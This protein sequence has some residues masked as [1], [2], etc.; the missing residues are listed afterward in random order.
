MNENRNKISS[1]KKITVVYLKVKMK[2]IPKRETDPDPRKKV[3]E[4][5]N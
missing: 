4:S 2:N 1:K 5:Q 3:R